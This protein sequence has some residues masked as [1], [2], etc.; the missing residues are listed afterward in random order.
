MPS[1]TSSTCPTSATSR[2]PRYC[3]ICLRRTEAISSALIFIAT[4]PHHFAPH[5]LQPVAYGALVDAIADADDHAGE[6]FRPDL[7]LDDDLASELLLQHLVQA[8]ALL[9]RERRRR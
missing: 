1:P 5:A 6:Q 2:A 8:G 4:A 3:S 9:G 7:G